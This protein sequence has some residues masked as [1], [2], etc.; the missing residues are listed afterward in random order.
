MENDDVRKRERPTSPAPMSH[1]EQ[2]LRRAASVVRLPSSPNQAPTV[3]PSGAGLRCAIT[4]TEYPIQDGVL[5]LLPK[6]TPK[7]LSQRS[8]DTRFTVRVYEAIRE[9]MLKVAGVPN[10]ETEVSS[11]Q[12]RL[13]IRPGDFVLDLACGHGN[14]TERWARFSGPEGLV[15]GLD[16]SRTM[17]SR[18]ATRMARS[19]PSSLLLIHADAQ[20][21]PLAATSFTKVNCSGGFHSFPD[22]PLALR[23]I[24]RVSSPGATLTAS[25]FAEDPRRPHPRLRKVLQAKF[26][27]HFVPLPWLGERLQEQGYSDYEWSIPKRW[28]AYTSAKK[29]SGSPS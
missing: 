20:S 14:F 25:T 23:E 16:L 5:D 18:A 7:T 29:K 19:D 28:F 9:S 21:L 22:L 13:Q 17:L 26:G 2:L 8:L 6:S 15:V 10:F 1:S 27:F 3:S 24:S 12:N 4:G 11:I